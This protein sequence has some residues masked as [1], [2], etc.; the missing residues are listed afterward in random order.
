[1]TGSA[2]KD[3]GDGRKVWPTTAWTPS[4]VGATVPDDWTAR[5]WRD[6]A[7]TARMWRDDDWSARM[8]RDQSW[9]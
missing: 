8:W 9:G 7:W 3:L 6:G 1:M 5:M 2:W 4:G